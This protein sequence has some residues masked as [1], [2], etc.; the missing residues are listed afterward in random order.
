MKLV[1]LTEEPSM[2]V[3]LEQLLPGVVKPPN[4][5]LII[6]HQGISDLKRSLPNKLRYWQEPDTR[7]LIL[8]DQDAADCRERKAEFDK[9]CGKYKRAGEYAVRVVCRELEAWFLGDVDALLA[10]G[11][12]GCQKLSQHRNKGLCLQPDAVTKPSDQLSRIMGSYQ[13]VSGAKAIAPHMQ[14]ARNTSLSFKTFV[15]KVEEFCRT[16]DTQPCI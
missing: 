13:K 5:F 15:A 14:I 8:V 4:T 1:V 10:S 12:A 7:F 16:P 3:L 11:I 2:Q 9:I 6:P